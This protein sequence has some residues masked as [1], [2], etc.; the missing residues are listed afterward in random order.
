MKTHVIT[1][2]TGGTDRDPY[3]STQS[4]TVEIIN[5]WHKLRWPDFPSRVTGKHVGYHIVC[6]A[7]GRWEVTRALWEEGAH[8]VGMNTSAVGVCFTGNFVMDKAKH[9]AVDQLT[10]E[11]KKAWVEEIWPYIKKHQPGIEVDK[12]QSHD[13]YAPWKNCHGDLYGDNYFAK[14]L[15]DGS[16]D[17]VEKISYLKTLVKL[18]MKLLAL[19]RENK[20]QTFMYNTGGPSRDDSEKEIIHRV[21][22]DSLKKD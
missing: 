20:S 5:G 2:N 14:L 1:H 16:D 8:T 12:I 4:H 10:E 7:D 11:Q 22:L 3:L 15:E 6:E 21:Y 9:L 18:Y 13:V 17:L 19:I